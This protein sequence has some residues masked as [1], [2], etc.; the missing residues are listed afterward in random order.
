[1]TSTIHKSVD[2]RRTRR[3]RY[4]RYINVFRKRFACTAAQV[5]DHVEAAIRAADHSAAIWKAK[6]EA[7]DLKVADLQRKIAELSK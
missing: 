7:L 2:A 3:Q 6:A 1:M 5:M 4:K